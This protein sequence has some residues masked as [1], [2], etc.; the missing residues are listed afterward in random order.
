MERS[1]ERN[2]ESMID[3][4]RRRREL[5][6]KG[7][8]FQRFLVSWRILVSPPNLLSLVASVDKDERGSGVCG[9]SLQEDSS[10][11]EAFEYEEHLSPGGGGGWLAAI[12]HVFF[13]V[14]HD[15]LP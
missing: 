5:A 13:L 14:H 9:S 12:L 3:E 4:T 8:F 10:I 15:L 11:D 7:S 6:M 1:E 2:Y